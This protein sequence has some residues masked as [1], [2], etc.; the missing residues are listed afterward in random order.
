MARS[1]HG[2][3]PTVG[4]QHVA[5]AQPFRHRHKG[6]IDESQPCIRVLV[7]DV[8]RSRQIIFFQKLDLH[9]PSLNRSGQLYFS[10]GS[11][12]RIDQITGF[13]K[14]G[15]WD[16]QVQARRVQK[17]QDAVMPRIVL[18]RH[19]IERTGIDEDRLHL[20]RRAGTAA[21]SNSSARSAT[22]FRPLRPI[23]RKDGRVFCVRRRPANSSS[24]VLIVAERLT[25]FFCAISCSAFSKDSSAKIVVRFMHTP[26]MHVCYLTLN[27]PSSCAEE[28]RHCI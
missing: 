4:R 24:A 1:D 12:M 20:L 7:H 21:Q 17:R 15:D 2:K 25:R 13:R 3:V 27:T 18:I 5:Y 26:C 22:S 11:Q 19:G 23:A 16:S 14:N 28:F 8:G 9:L 6:S 10:R